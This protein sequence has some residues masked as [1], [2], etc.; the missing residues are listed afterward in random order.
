MA[1]KKK[2]DEF[3]SCESD[4]DL[5]TQNSFYPLKHST[6]SIKFLIESNGKPIGFLEENLIKKVKSTVGKK[7][8]TEKAQ[9]IKIGCNFGEILME[10]YTEKTPKKK[11][12]KSW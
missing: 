3:T 8:S 12:Y 10:G 4:D 9:I 2:L 7:C 1:R 5:N 6:A 11:L